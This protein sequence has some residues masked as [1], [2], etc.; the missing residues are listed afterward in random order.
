MTTGKRQH[1]N[2]LRVGI[3]ERMHPTP[4]LG[5]NRHRLRTVRVASTDESLALSA[6]NFFISAT[7][8]E[9]PFLSFLLELQREGSGDK[10]L[11]D[12]HTRHMIACVDAAAVM[13]PLMLT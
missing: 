5:P 13:S 7:T 11:H 12:L 6:I 4:S 10:F 2:K 8:P 3:R 1:T 9:K